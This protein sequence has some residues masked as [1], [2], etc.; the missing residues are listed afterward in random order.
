VKVPIGLQVQ[1][2]G[3]LARSRILLGRVG[4]TAT[5]TRL[6]RPGKRKEIDPLIATRAVHRAGRLVGGTCL[7]QCVALTALLQQRAR[8]PE[9]VLGCRR[10]V[11][12]EWTAHAWV[13]VDEHIYEPVPGGRNAP[14]A[15][16]RYADGWLPTAVPQDRL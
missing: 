10:N 2:I 7:P 16:L 1:A 9:L 4:T 6:G 11:D 15:M 12:G 3:M 8:A 14:L 13:L 5:L